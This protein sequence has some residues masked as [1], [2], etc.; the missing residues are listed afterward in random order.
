MIYITQIRSVSIFTYFFHLTC[1]SLQFKFVGN[2]W[3]DGSELVAK[4]SVNHK[5][6]FTFDYNSSVS[7]SIFKNTFCTFKNRNEY[8][9]I[10][11]NRLIHH[12][13]A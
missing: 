5:N 13:V 1:R 11:Y 4:Y 12:L 10:I 8:S 7:W 2:I 6:Q 9:T 3:N